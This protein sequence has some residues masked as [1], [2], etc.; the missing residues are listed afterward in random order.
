MLIPNVLDKINLLFCLID[1]MKVFYIENNIWKILQDVNVMFGLRVFEIRLYKKIIFNFKNNKS[2]L[3]EINCNI[4]F[5]NG[6]GMF[7]TVLVF[8]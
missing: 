5:K 4:G 7:F 6:C 3:K 8:I 1:F 2:W